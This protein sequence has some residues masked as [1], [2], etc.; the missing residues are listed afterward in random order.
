MPSSSRGRDG[1]A[2]EAQ[3]DRQR[4]CFRGWTDGRASCRVANVRENTLVC[5]YEPP[6]AWEP[7][8]DWLR[9]RAIPGVER[10]DGE[11]Y[12]RTF[13]LR[14]ERGVV[15]VEPVAPGALQVTVRGASENVLPDIEARVRRVFDLDA[16]VAAI[17]AHLA[18]DRLLSPLVAQRPG[19]RV[20][21]AWT[22]F[23]LAIRAV[24]GQQISVAAARNLAGRLVERCGAKLSAAELTHVFPAAQAVASADLSSFGVP[25]SRAATLIAVAR[26]ELDDPMLF[27]ATDELTAAVTK[28]R[29]IRGVGEWTAQYIALRQLRLRDAFPATDLGI[30]KGAAKLL[31][32][33][34]SPRELV[35]RA[36]RWRPWRAYA[37]QY[38]WSVS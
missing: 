36:E 2:R 21:G 27:S 8:L 37:A 15:A 26:A 34:I 5:R 12:S 16:D 18:R 9:R 28:L 11:R 29:A 30:L 13:E 25:K 32:G 22:G 4:V 1:Y 19:L 31:G 38:L 14:G 17:G 24:L 3:T 33:E 23:E 6:Y 35:V 7:M 20:P 10:V